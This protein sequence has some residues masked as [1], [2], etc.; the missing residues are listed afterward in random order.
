MEPL[1]VHACLHE[2]YPR[3]FFKQVVLRAL[4]ELNT[5]EITR[6][7]YARITTHDFTASLN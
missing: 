4:A 1:L 7:A 6:I 2:M 3:V 5:S